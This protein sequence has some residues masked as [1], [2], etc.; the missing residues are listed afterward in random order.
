MKQIG[1]PDFNDRADA[2]L[3]DSL[4]ASSFPA[5]DAPKGIRGRRPAGC[6]RRIKTPKHKAAAAFYTLLSARTRQLL[7]VNDK[8]RNEIAA[9]A[10]L[11]DMLRQARKM[12]AIGH[13]AS[14][15]VHDF[16]NRL[17]V[18][19]VSLEMMRQRIDTGRTDGLQ[20]YI[21]NAVTSTERAAALSRRLLDLARCHTFDPR[22]ID[23]QHVIE[24]STE[25]F[26]SLIGQQIALEIVITGKPWPIFCDPNELE[27]A[28]LN[29]IINARHA[30]PDGGR[31]VIKV[32]NMVVDEA[33][34]ITLGKD[35][36]PGE[37]VTIEL[38]DTGVG[39]SEE[40]I[41]RAFE[42]FFTTKPSSVGTGLGLPMV[43]G[44]AEQAG[45]SIRVASELGRG[46][47]FSLYLPSCLGR[48]KATAGR[49]ASMPA[50]R[51]RP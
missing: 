2:S 43:C 50:K 29:L 6:E 15:I 12:E 25:L 10:Q 37:F 41:A 30:M 4:A 11:E 27:N 22:P 21:S 8:L 51:P 16:N 23:V 47:T 7:V 5:P 40:V 19:M 3:L 45:G 46:S 24:T 49:L 33:A 9:R 20:K 26:R 38:I 42:P 31:L 1:Q 17:N 35:L 34:S 28:I 36:G 32:S 13:V 18:I 48:A 39:M 14:S 44:F